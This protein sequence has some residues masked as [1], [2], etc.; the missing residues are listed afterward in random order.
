MKRF[1]KLLP[2]LEGVMPGYQKDA[3]HT[4]DFLCSIVIYHGLH[5]VNAI[6][7]CLRADFWEHSTFKE[8]L[9]NPK[10]STEHPYD[11]HL[12]TLGK[13][14]RSEKIWSA[15]QKQHLAHKSL[16]MQ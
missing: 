16:C 12:R 15:Y 6:F 2:G 14:P 13:S 11:V 10:L 3:K 4:L 5:Y 9:E 7:K 1:R 8:N